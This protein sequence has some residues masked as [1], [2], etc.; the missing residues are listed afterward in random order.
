M[1]IVTVEEDREVKLAAWQ[2]APGP[3]TGFVGR[4]RQCAVAS[5][6]N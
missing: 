2:Y 3:R 6:T 5:Y 4:V 1:G